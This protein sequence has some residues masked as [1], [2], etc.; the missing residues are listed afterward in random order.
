MNLSQQLGF[1][2]LQFSSLTIFME[3]DIYRDG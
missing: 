2:C 1:S 3:L